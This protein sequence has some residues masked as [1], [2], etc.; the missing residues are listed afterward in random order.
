MSG[1]SAATRRFGGERIEDHHGIHAAQRGQQLGTLILRRRWAGPA[2]APRSKR[3]CSGPRPAHRPAPAPPADNARGPR[4]AGRNGRWSDDDRMRPAPALRFTPRAPRAGIE[5]LKTCPSRHVPQFCRL[6]R[7]HRPDE[8]RQGELP[9]PPPRLR[10]QP[11][12]PFQVQPLH[13][14]GRAP[15]ARRQCNRTCRRRPSSRARPAPSRCAAIHRS[16]RGVP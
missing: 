1:R 10:D 6:F 7:A 14:A 4:A 3:R 11:E 13:P 2:C 8:A 16:C 15:S 9:P 12:Q 5:T